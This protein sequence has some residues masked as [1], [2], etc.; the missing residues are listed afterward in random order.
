MTAFKLATILA[1]QLGIDPDGPQ[2]D[3]LLADANAML[4]KA[5][6]DPAAAWWD[7]RVLNGE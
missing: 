2:W 3:D 4:D 6:D 5:A 7:L 1:A